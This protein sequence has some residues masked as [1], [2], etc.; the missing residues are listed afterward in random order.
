MHNK[1]YLVFFLNTLIFLSGIACNYNRASK[2]KFNVIEATISQ[3]HQAFKKGDLTARQLVQVYLDRIEAYDQPTKLN[4]I[5]VVNSNALQV[6]DELDDE[7]NRTG[8]LR[9]LHGI[10]IIVKD[11][12]DTNDLPT[13]GGSLA[14]KGSM[15]PDDAFQIEKIREAGAI[16]LGKSN[17]AEWAFS[18]YKTESSIAGITRNPY[19][20][21]RVPAGSSGGTA[22]AVAANLALAGLGTDTGNSIRGPSSH[23]NLIGI[24]STMGA[25]SRDGII[26]LMLRNDIGGPFARTVEDAVR[27]FEVIVGYDPK[28]P[29]TKRSQGKIPDSYLQYLSANSLNGARIGIFRQYINTP[30]ADPE[31][32]AITENAINDLESAGA[33]IV[34]PFEIQNYNELINEIWCNVFQYDLNNY[35]TTLGENAPVKSLQDIKNSGLYLPYIER[36]IDSSLKNTIPPL[37]RDPICGDLYSSPQNI[38]FTEAV[39]NAMDEADIDAFIYPTWSNPPRK[40]GDMESPA[41]DNSQYLSPHTGMPAITVP[42]GFTKNGLPTGITFIG[43]HFDEPKI[44]GY[45]YSYEQETHHRVAPQKFKRLDN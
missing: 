43:R 42:S 11:N 12:Y 44:F 40:V 33:E 10:P 35:L 18:A 37:E 9:P 29:I 13:T 21:T 16:I 20:L 2:Q 17:M 1:R 15:A 19:D 25:T 26:P 36:M 7:F 27:I 8:M 38:A 24:R 41:G 4:A 22:A 3:V 23:N 39:N 28:D 31:I 32:I 5:V 30:T 6:A 14:M 34:D 45:V